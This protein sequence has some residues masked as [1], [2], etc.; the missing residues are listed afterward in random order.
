M[1]TNILFLI[2]SLSPDG[3]GEIMAVQIAESLKKS[4]RYEPIVCATRAGGSLEEP[5][6][7]NNIEYM[8]L[9]RKSFIDNIKFRS[10]IQ[11]IKNKNIRIVHSH[12]LGSNF[13]GAIIGTIARVPILIAHKHGQDHKSISSWVA[14]SIVSAL[15]DTLVFVSNKERAEFIKRFSRVSEKCITIYNGVN[16]HKGNPTGALADRYGGNEDSLKVGIVAR[17]S[18]EKNHEMFLLAAREVLKN[19]NNVR[20]FLIG[21][22]EKRKDIEN[23]ASKL[24]ISHKT[25]FTG[26]IKDLSDIIP[27]LDI[28]CL[29]SRREGMGLALLDYMS[30]EKPIVSTNVGGIS[31]VVK[32]GVNGFLVPSSDYDSM[33]DKIITLL[34]DQDLRNKMG[35]E[36]YIILNNNFTEKIMIEK[37][38]KLYDEL[39]LSSSG[40]KSDM[41]NL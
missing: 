33:A 32:D 26:F 6:K 19:E 27:I 36:G 24:G 31:E 1:A 22:G 5:L 41:E 20:F 14:D 11:T 10:L 34:H 21:D 28:G 18:A 40:Q 12:K 13:W 37:L 23:L 3:G 16:I 38:E 25:V 8:L 17:F 35:K 7:K 9:N 15:S 30:F 29:T 39:I 2:D 4:G